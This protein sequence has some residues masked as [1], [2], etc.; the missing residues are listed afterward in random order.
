MSMK[1]HKQTKETTCKVQLFKHTYM[2]MSILLPMCE[3]LSYSSKIKQ[4]VLTAV[5]GTQ[6]LYS[7]HVYMYVCEIIPHLDCTAHFYCGS[8]LCD[9]DPEMCSVE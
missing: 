1:H 4:Y 9:G 6:P 8:V 2:H 5:W 7:V 3:V